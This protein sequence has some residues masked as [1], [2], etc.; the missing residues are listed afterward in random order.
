MTVE[1]LISFKVRVNGKEITL[2]PK[3]RVKFRDEIAERLIAEGRVRNV[4]R[5]PIK[6]YSRLFNEEIWLAV[7][8]EEME[9][10]VSRGVKEVV[11]MAGEIPVLK[12]LD[13]DRLKVVHM[14]KKTLPGAALA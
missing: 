7:T 11:Y 4:E 10:L 3:Q 8:K 1:V 5:C 9:V 6:I 12:D 14:I 13:K 2:A